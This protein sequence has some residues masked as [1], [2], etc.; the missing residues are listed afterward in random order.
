MLLFLF[1]LLRL[2]KAGFTESTS[3]RLIK[4][5][6]DEKLVVEMRPHRGSSPAI[7][8]FPRLLKIT[9]DVTFT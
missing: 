3:R 1:T 5:L 6:K 7:L 9:E 2:G 8:A 4:L